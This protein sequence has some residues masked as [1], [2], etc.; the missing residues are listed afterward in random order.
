M[1]TIS[2]ALAAS[3]SLCSPEIK[4]FSRSSSAAA[5]RPPAS[6]HPALLPC[7]QAPKRGDGSRHPQHLAEPADRPPGLAERW[8][9]APPPLAFLASHGGPEGPQALPLSTVTNTQWGQRP[10]TGQRSRALSHPQARPPGVHLGEAPS[11]TPKGPKVMRCTLVPQS[12]PADRKDAKIT[13]Q[14]LCHAWH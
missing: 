1:E 3:A 7:G 4:R 5:A 11:W 14:T 2:R 10:G 13:S 12:L 9:P 8:Q 6:G